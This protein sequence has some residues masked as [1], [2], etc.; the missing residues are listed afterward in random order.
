MLMEE[1]SIY[2]EDWEALNKAL[3]VLKGKSSK[4][5]LI[6]KMISLSLNDLAPGYENQK[7]P[8]LKRWS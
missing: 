4:A 8:Y 5:E 1:I 7:L 3:K 6:H 2:K